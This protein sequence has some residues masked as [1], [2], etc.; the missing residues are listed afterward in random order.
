MLCTTLPT[1]EA[2][3][4]LAEGL[5][6]YFER[7][8]AVAHRASQKGPVPRT[9][10]GAR[11]PREEATTLVETFLSESSPQQRQP[12]HGRVRVVNFQIVLGGR[13]H[14]QAAVPPNPWAAAALGR[15]DDGDGAQC[16]ALLLRQ[17]R[18]RRLLRRRAR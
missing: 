18:S 4:L 11:Q 14:Q 15:H 16:D 10:R 3:K 5:R 12:R 1:I 17:G 6:H 2:A 9:I 13:A 7:D 8:A